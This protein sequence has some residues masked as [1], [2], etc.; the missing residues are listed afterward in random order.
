MRINSNLTRNRAE[1]YG[2]DL[3]NEFVIPP[4]YSQLELMKSEK[5]QI[6]EGG[7]GSGKTMLI[8]Y[9]CHTTQFSPKRQTITEADYKRVGIYW[10][11]DVQFSKLMSMRGADETLWLNAFINMGVLVLTKEIIE[12]LY[13]IKSINPIAG[14]E[15]D[16]IDFGGLQDFDPLIPSHLDTL[17]VYINSQYNKFQSWVSNYKK[18]EQ[19]IFYPKHFLDCIITIIKTHVTLLRN[20][21]YSVYI[22]EYENLI[23]T[24]K[25]IINTWVKHSQSPIIFNIA[26]KHNSL[27][28]TET[29]SDE[30]IVEIHDYRLIDI[31]RL[32]KDYFATFASEIFLLK[33]H[34]NLVP[35][36][37]ST[38]YLFDT[39]PETLNKRTTSKYI[40]SINNKIAKIFPKISSR[41][42]AARMVEDDKIRNKLSSY[43]ENDLIEL[44]QIQYLNQCFDAMTVPEAFVILHALF[45]RS[46]TN[47]PDIMEQ[48]E[49]YSQGKESKFREWIH[50]NLVGCILNIYGKLNR[51]CPLYSGYDTFLTMS[52]DNIRHFLELCYTSLA[53]SDNFEQQRVDIKDQMTAVKYVSDNMLNE[54][55][56]LGASGNILYIFAY[57]LGNLFEEFRKRDSQSEPEQN[58]FSI[59]GELTDESALILNE[60]IKWS[61][62][63][64][65]KLTKQK[66]MESGSEY[67]FN[68]IY[69]A[70]FTISYRKKRRIEISANDFQ[71]LCFGNSDDYNRLLKR[72]TSKCV[73]SKDLNSLSLFD[74]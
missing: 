74:E 11:M 28:V 49:L 20:S 3:W 17:R 62:L 55:K 65:T 56:Q 12:S 45:S 18:I 21:F 5:P 61:V 30:H 59:K 71:Q 7:R 46:A 22:D 58:Q 37:D 44:K 54:I 36:F 60:L 32:L 4:Y 25:R 16:N 35:I 47:V 33:V 27:D 26:M 66:A 29:L 2:F 6:I 73:S 72:I 9:L 1:E 31:E 51:L 8:R 10:K 63:Y 13:N 42:I 70:Y 34:I 14:K 64:R 41:D 50:N 52:K 67:Q 43:I 23:D 68:P 19:P 15:I 69:S 38:D 39:S 53:H 40:D 24:H 48:L 57:R